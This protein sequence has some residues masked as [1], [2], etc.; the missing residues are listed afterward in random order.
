MVVEVI[1]RAASPG[2]VGEAVTGNVVVEV[3]AG[4]VPKTVVPAVPEIENQGIVIDHVLGI[5][6]VDLEI[7]K[8]GNGLEIIEAAAKIGMY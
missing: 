3:V 6:E 8:I 4:N 2:I 7:V 1:D 5:N